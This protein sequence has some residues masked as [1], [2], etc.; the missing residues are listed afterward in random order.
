MKTPLSFDNDLLAL[1]QKQWME[2]PLTEKEQLL[3]NSWKAA[4]PENEAFLNALNLRNDEANEELIVILQ[5]WER[6]NRDSIWESSFKPLDSTG[7]YVK[8][9]FKKW[10]W[11]AAAI[12]CLIAGSAYLWFVQV[13]RN[14]NEAV[15]QVL[16]N[17]I[18]PGKNGAV[19][20]LSDGKQIVLD[21]LGTGVIAMEN[22]S[23]LLLGQGQLSYATRSDSNISET[24]NTL[25]T[26]KGR[27]FS[28]QLADGTKVW[29]N[30]ESSIRYPTK[31]SGKERN[32]SVTGEVYFE[33]SGDTRKPFR[34]LV[35][36][37]NNKNPKAEIEVLG[38]TFN[39]NA[40]EDEQFLRT[41]LVSGV[42]RVSKSGD[43]GNVNEGIVLKPGE[44]AQI[45][46]EIKVIKESNVRQ[47]AAW[48]EGI[49]NFDGIALDEVLRQIARW[50]DLEVVYT[51]GVPAINIRAELS[52]NVQLKTIINGLVDSKVKCRVEGRKLIVEN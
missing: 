27:Q 25:I 36:S 11:A 12:V 5:H 44:Q 22:G 2:Q 52:R 24:F 13:G 47:V 30:A 37:L 26:P 43:A 8:P 16:V 14:W 4:S 39:I 28:L 51:N 46:D 23:E 20:T 19:L 34:V 3:L 6:D 15:E 45:R 35:T 38:T 50:Y 32:V 29:L 21:S 10:G 31:F 40:Y 17:N 33:V 9:L 7:A 49:F 42:V 48:K 1:L 41:T 18:S